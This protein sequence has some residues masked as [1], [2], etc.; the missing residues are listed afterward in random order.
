MT[1]VNLLSYTG[2]GFAEPEIAAAKILVATK[3]TR[4]N[5][6]T[7][8]E[9][10]EEMEKSELLEELD[11]MAT[12]I[13]SSWEFLDLTFLVEGVTRA[14]AQQI[15]RT[16]TGSYAMQSQR[17]TN[18][19][20]M[21][22]KNPFTPNTLEHDIFEGGV[23]TSSSTYDSLMEEGAEP[24][25]ARGI[26]PMNTTCNIWCKYNLR[27]FADLLAARKSNRTQSEYRDIVLEM[28]KEVLRVWPWAEKFFVPKN[29][30][31]LALLDEVIAELGM[32][33]GSGAGWKLAKVQDL[34]R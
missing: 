33:T 26:L 10:V 28:E 11:Y 4:L 5:V 34:L 24:G 27:S 31:A 18:A 25:D 32:T 12:T 29:E 15:T 8:L 6:T 13:P 21:E 19:S 17:V 7:A 16:R 2:Q 20:E 14:T 22:V 3:N 23:V 30:K 9:R 1:K